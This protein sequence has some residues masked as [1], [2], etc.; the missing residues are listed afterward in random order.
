MNNKQIEYQETNEQ[1]YLLL[2]PCGFSMNNND[3]KHDKRCNCSFACN[4]TKKIGTRVSHPSACVT[5]TLTRQSAFTY[6]VWKMWSMENKEYGKCGV[7]KM[8]S[9]ENVEYGKCVLCFPT[10]QRIST[11]YS[12]R[13]GFRSTQGIQGTTTYRYNTFILNFMARTIIHCDCYIA[14]HFLT[15]WI[16]ST[17]PQAWATCVRTEQAMLISSLLYCSFFREL[18]TTSLQVE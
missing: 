5:H 2:C 7:W 8:W 11:T 18:G 1:S 3:K 16:P 15:S 6:G 17:L 4:C 10:P 9:M 13:I 12:G 14:I